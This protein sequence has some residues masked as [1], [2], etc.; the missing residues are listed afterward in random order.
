V[1][2]ILSD[3]K[4]LVTN[5][6]GIDAAGIAALEYAAQHVGERVVVAPAGPQ[7]GVSHAVTT[8]RAVMLEDIGMQRI[9]VHGTPAD[10]VRI[11]LLNIVPDAKFV[12]SGVNH[13]GNLGADVYYSGTVAA[14][15]EA[16]LHGWTGVA[17][18]QYK[19]KTLDF[20]WPRTAAWAARVL[21][22][23]L[24]RPPRRGSFFNVNFPHL[25]P[26]DPD[27]EVVFCP[28]DPHPLPLSYRHE[29]TGLVYD[30]NYH[31]RERAAGADVDVCFSGRIAV[32]ELRLL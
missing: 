25:L 13:G 24:A 32:T 29:E 8:G 14:V 27:P 7:S 17:L 4:L 12:L 10:C 26:T 22:D 11:G 18:S 1:G 28:L 3:M 23:L 5:D 2:R 6:D 15:R 19:K 20:D 30:G 21:A 31:L 9:R 16:V